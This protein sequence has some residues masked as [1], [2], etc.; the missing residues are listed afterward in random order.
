MCLLNVLWGWAYRKFLSVKRVA[1]SGGMSG[2]ATQNRRVNVAQ[3]TMSL[4][5]RGMSAGIILLEST[6]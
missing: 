4:G 1:Q 5:V 2:G 3:M 6:T